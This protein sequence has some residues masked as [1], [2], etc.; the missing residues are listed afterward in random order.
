MST[1]LTVNCNMK[2]VHSINSFSFTLVLISQKAFN[3]CGYIACL[4]Y[5]IEINF[6]N[7]DII[8]NPLLFHVCMNNYPSFVM[9]ATSQTLYVIRGRFLDM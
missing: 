6:N 4:K 9:E 1:K 8:M 7:K 2:D 3:A 5:K